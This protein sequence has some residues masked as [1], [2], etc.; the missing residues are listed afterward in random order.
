[1][2]NQDIELMKKDM[3]QEILSQIQ[4]NQQV[5]QNSKTSWD[6]KV[7]SID[8]KRFTLSSKTY[9]EEICVK[10]TAGYPV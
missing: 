1:M 2:T 4:A 8:K 7:I 3:E 5:L 9:L 10:Y 6:L